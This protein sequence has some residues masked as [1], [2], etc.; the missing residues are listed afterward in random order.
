M[1]IAA[2][3]IF[4][5]VEIIEYRSHI[6]RNKDLSSSAVYELTSDFP[7]ANLYSN[8]LCLTVRGHALP[9]IFDIN[10]VAY[11]TLSSEDCQL[12]SVVAKDEVVS[13]DSAF[14][15]NYMFYWL[16]GTYILFRATVNI[17]STLTVYLYDSKLSFDLCSDHISNDDWLEIWTFDFS[18]HH[19]C[20]LISSLGVMS[21]EFQ[22]NVTSSGYYYLC[23][24]STVENGLLYN[25][26]ISSIQY[27]TS[28]RRTAVQCFPDQECC[29]SFLSVFEEVSNPTC[30]FVSTVPLIPTYTGIVLSDVEIRVD[31]RL[32]VIWYCVICL[33][34]LLAVLGCGS[35]LC[36]IT[37]RKVKNQNVFS[38]GC[39]LYCNIYSSKYDTLNRL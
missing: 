2:I 33:V 20:V 11:V 4:W 38:R 15:H 19:S 16:N 31:Q 24:D 25:L 10:K 14:G 27:D 17:T 6:S 36:R 13:Q 29:L 28:Q 34:P 12:V 18:K 21:C 35:L 23:M 22:F 37:S 30:M 5:L 32:S 3:G 26:T 1:I 8:Q 9:T 39:V 7:R